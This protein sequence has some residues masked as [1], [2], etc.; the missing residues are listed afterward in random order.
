MVF[1]LLSKVELRLIIFSGFLANSGPITAGD[2]QKGGHFVQLCD[3]RDIPLVFLQNSSMSGAPGCD[4]ATLKE[5][6]KLVQCLSVVRVPR[7]SL[8]VGGV[9]GDENYT[10]CG[11]A[12]EP[13]F[14]FM[15]PRSSLLMA[16][17][18]D[19]FLFMSS[20]VTRSP[21]TIKIADVKGV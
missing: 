4:A 21:P 18:G 16:S 15:W 10:M 19:L 7:I 9:T 11:P 17:P 1:P 6:A 13:N 8:N 20:L 3:N 12:F 14:Y 2:A 5:R